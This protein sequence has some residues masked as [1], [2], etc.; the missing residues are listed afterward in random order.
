VDCATGVA[1]GRIILTAQENVD[2][3]LNLVNIHDGKG[4]KARTVPLDPGGQA[5]AILE[6]LL[7]ESRS[8][9]VFTSPH[10]GGKFTRVD[11]SL[12]RV[13]E[14]AEVSDLTIRVFRHTFCTRLAA[15]GV[16]VRTIQRLQA[17]EIHSSGRVKHI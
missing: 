14:L 10:S 5:R 13:S 1:T 16:D 6:R 12:K 7:I 15:A 2:L 4:G 9:Y 8:E 11:K 3:T 17:D